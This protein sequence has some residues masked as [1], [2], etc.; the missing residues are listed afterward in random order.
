MT[1][2]FAW[3]RRFF[4][5]EL[6]GISLTVPVRDEMGFDIRVNCRRR[7]LK[8][9]STQMSD[10]L[11]MLPRLKARSGSLGGST[12]QLRYPTTTFGRTAE[13]DYRF[14]G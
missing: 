5:R 13:C 8:H 12:L 10:L 11:H 7:R 14:R 1:R 3:S 6:A 9:E 2:R 4:A